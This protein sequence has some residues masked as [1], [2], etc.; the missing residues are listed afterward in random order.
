MPTFHRFLQL[1]LLVPM[2][3][4]ERLVILAADAVQVA[5]A[6]AVV[7]AAEVAGDA[8]EFS[9]EPSVERELQGP[10]ACHKSL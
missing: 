9:H 5:V 7:D 1:L 10:M 8:V 6:V 4:D 3:G 2:T